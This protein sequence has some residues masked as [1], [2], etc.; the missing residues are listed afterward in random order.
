MDDLALGSIRNPKE[1]DM[2]QFGFWASG[3]YMCKCS[4]CG[5]YFFGDKR[6]LTC[7]DCAKIDKEKWD[8]LTKEEREEQT[9]KNIEDV[10]DLM[11]HV[12]R[13]S[14]END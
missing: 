1:S 5:D 2:P 10:K 14:R 11:D 3:D 12:Y 7:A 6:A 9:R 8:A 13:I 4:A